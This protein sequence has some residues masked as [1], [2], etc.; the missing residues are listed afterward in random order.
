MFQLN[1]HTA[2]IIALVY[3]HFIL[4]MVRWSGNV[5]SQLLMT[6]HT[7]ASGTLK[8]PASQSAVSFL[9]IVI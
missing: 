1:A 3:Q 9:A 6:G 8:S 4:S 7:N 5:A 2:R